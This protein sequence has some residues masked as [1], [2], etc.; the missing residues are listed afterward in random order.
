MSCCAITSA[1]PPVHLLPPQVDPCS[2]VLAVLREGGVTVNDA[3][4]ILS[5]SLRPQVCQPAAG[6]H[7]Q[8]T[9]GS[10]RKQSSSTNAAGKAGGDKDATRQSPS[11][12]SDGQQE[13][14][15]LSPLT[16]LVVRD[17]MVLAARAGGWL[18]LPSPQDRC[19]LPC[20][21]LDCSFLA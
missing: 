10:P 16:Q 14:P 21:A 13:L 2:R 19:R 7:P 20:W 12:T 17:A 3:N 6:G 1:A 5:K 18:P 8:P 9:S 15:G 4:A 11:S